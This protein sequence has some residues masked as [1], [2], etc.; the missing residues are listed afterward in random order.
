[1]RR[2]TPLV[3]LSLVACTPSLADS[4]SPAPGWPDLADPPI[5]LTDGRSD[6][7]LI[8]VIDDPA[9]DG[10]AGAWQVGS[11]WW[12][13]LVR[14]RGLRSQR[15][16]LL[17][18][19]A[20]TADAIA[21]AVE[22]MKYRSGA[23]SMLWLIFIGGGESSPDGSRRLHVGDRSL[24]LEPLRRQLSVG[25]HESAFI[26]LDGCAESP[27]P[28][29]RSGIPAEAAPLELAAASPRLGAGPEELVF[30]S[31]MESALTRARAQVQLDVEHQRS[32]PR[33]TFVLTAGTGSACASTIADRPW[34]A[35]SYAAL[36]GLQGWADLDEDGW[37]SA[38]ELT[39][40]AQASIA[41]AQIQA[42]GVDLILADVAGRAPNS[43]PPA[44]RRRHQKPLDPGL[45][46]RTDASLQQAAAL[47]QLDLEDM[48]AVPGG[49]FFMG[50][51]RDNDDA[52]ESDEYPPH[53]VALDGF[54][55]DRT[56]VRWAEYRACMA[57]GA[58]PPMHL[59]AC[60]VWNGDAFERGDPLPAEML[61]DDHPVV[62]VTWS[63]AARYCEAMGKR[64]PTEAEWER[65]ARGVDGRLYP[66]GNQAPSC[67]TTV[68]HNCS[69]FTRPVG[70]RSGGASPVGA[71]DMAGN[72]AEW[73]HDWWDQGSYG[74][75]VLPNPTG[76]SAGQVRGV[77]GGSFYNGDTDLRVSYRYG[78]D[79]LARTSIVGF[80]CAR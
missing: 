11:G 36:G 70:S 33:N 51:D 38:R 62:C 40:H 64:L 20:A 30:A 7:A 22:R 5:G 24:E 67:T 73:V 26:L 41:D 29:Y 45:A 72:V 48:V 54:A 23:G 3:L 55:I 50:C 60:W 74:R 66:W 49:E 42:G 27:S 17:R 21:R 15:V 2:F 65:A 63:E 32:T 31:G 8:V 80:R 76:P 9:L 44:R 47:V 39:I 43:P 57:S 71:L 53:N 12:R 25:Y 18:N 52:C 77:R 19:H 46:R 75:A 58:C 59:E 13:Y 34:P 14:T 78:L 6:A 37:V 10:R 35:L 16:E 4:A 56:E 68:M 69:D 1:M 79:P 28:G 61:A